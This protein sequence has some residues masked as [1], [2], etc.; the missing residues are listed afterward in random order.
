MLKNKCELFIQK[1]V[2]LSKTVVN[3]I[4]VENRMDSYLA[5]K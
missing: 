5:I 4:E 3:Q 2:E 1:I